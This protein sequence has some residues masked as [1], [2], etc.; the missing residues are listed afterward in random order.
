MS[1]SLEVRKFLLQQE[2]VVPRRSSGMPAQRSGEEATLSASQLRRARSA[3]A[4]RARD[5][6]DC[7]LLLEM[8]GLLP[9]EED[10]GPSR[11]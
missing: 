10:P 2:G 4:G 9:D 5:A 11:E 3:V 8:L 6:D 7:R 1:G